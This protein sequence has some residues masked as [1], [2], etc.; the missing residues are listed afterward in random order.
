MGMQLQLDAGVSGLERLYAL[1]TNP[2][3]KI[4]TIIQPRPEDSH[5]RGKCKVCGGDVTGGVPSV[6]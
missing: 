5:R 3:A 1:A 2:D 6:I 4:H